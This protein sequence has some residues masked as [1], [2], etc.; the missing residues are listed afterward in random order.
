EFH[1][2]R[3]VVEVG[4]LCVEVTTTPNELQASVL[5]VEA[6]KLQ[7]MWSSSESNLRLETK[8][9]PRCSSVGYIYSYQSLE[10]VSSTW[11]SNSPKVVKDSDGPTLLLS[12]SFAMTQNN[13][14]SDSV[15]ASYHLVCE[16]FSAEC[17][18]R[19]P[20]LQPVQMTKEGAVCIDYPT[21]VSTPELLQD[22][23]KKAFG[24]EPDCL[25]IIVVNKLPPEYPKYRERLLRLAERFAAMKEERREKYADPKSRYSFG[26]S[27]GK[28]IMNGKPDTLKGSYYAN[29]TVDYPTVS[30]EERQAHPE[31]YGR[32]IWPEANEQGVEGFEEAFKDLGRIGANGPK[33]TASAHL[34][35]NSVSLSELIKTSQT[36]KARLLHYFPPSAENPLPSDDEPV[37][38]CLTGLC[39]AIYLSHE[40]DGSVQ[41]VSSPSPASGLY[42]RTR[43]GDLTKVSIPVDSLAF[44]TGEALELATAGEGAEKVSRETFALFM[45][46]D[47]TRV[48]AE[49]ETF[50]SFSKKVFDEHYEPI[51]QKECPQSVRV[52]EIVMHDTNE[53][54]FLSNTLYQLALSGIRWASVR[55][56]TTLIIELL[57]LTF[58]A[59]KESRSM[60]VGELISFPGKTPHSIRRDGGRLALNLLS[61]PYPQM[62]RSLAGD[63]GEDMSSR[64]RLLNSS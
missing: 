9:Q 4:Y 24:S 5:K 2:V 33:I 48:I 54:P 16:M 27:H 7:S 29:P 43:G 51:L 26:W 49:G 50:G 6:S 47:T 13:L 28:E 58:H 30:E 11:T 17:L 52:L 14:V 41:L 35:D 19:H 31:Y 62:T 18:L 46:P 10:S 37:D 8:V 40:A 53:P 25:G 23:I 36:T 64:R 42:I 55:L 22:S 59:K 63:H 38:S 32:N 61:T 56:F 44:Q 34:T 57:A 60:I 39:S 12:R 20:P 15:H 1:A 3:Q 45:Q 21:L